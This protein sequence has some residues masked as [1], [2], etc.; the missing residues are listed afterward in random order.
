MFLRKKDATLIHY[1]VILPL[2]KK[3]FEKD[4]LHLEQYVHSK[5]PYMILVHEALTSLHNDLRQLKR[6]QKQ[7]E[8]RVY[9]VNADETFSTYGYVCNRYEGQNRYVN[10]NLQRQTERCMTRYLQGARFFTDE[11]ALRE[12]QR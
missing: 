6:V 7:R 4:H 11:G 2:V 9:L 1:A 12:N 3:T 5:A 8:I 10:A